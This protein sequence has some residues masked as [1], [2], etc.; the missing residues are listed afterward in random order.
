MVHGTCLYHHDDVIDDA[1][2]R[3][4]KPTINFHCGQKKVYYTAKQNVSCDIVVDSFLRHK[5]IWA[6][7]FVL[8]RALETISQI[9]NNEVCILLT[10]VRI[11]SSYL[12]PIK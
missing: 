12:I 3:R 2:K 10:R 5:S 7:D 9:P 4:A 8:G 1:I 11:D 6:G